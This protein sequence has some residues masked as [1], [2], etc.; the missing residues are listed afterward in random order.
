MNDFNFPLSEKKEELIKRALEE[1]QLPHYTLYQHI[2]PDG[3]SYIG[4]TKKKP[5]LR[6]G[7]DGIGYKGQKVYPKIQ[8]YGWEN[9]EHIILTDNIPQGK[10]PKIE[11]KAIAYFD[12]FNNGY[13]DDAGK[14]NIDYTYAFYMNRED[15]KIE[16]KEDFLT[17]NIFYHNIILAL[18]TLSH[19]GFNTFLYL[20]LRGKITHVNYKPR[21]IDN[22]GF[23]S[24]EFIWGQDF[25]NFKLTKKKFALGVKN[26]IENYY[27]EIID[28]NEKIYFFSERPY[29]SPY[30]TPE[31]GLISLNYVLKSSNEKE[32]QNVLL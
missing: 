11:Q 15:M 22:Y 31:N 25:E 20:L 21:F 17:L 28:E 13:N 1:H 10:A 8:K 16:N 4:I 29:T 14:E 23:I 2:F 7:K 19:D 30:S 9:I 6:W 26:L 24:P 18:K 5:E 27:V 3:K 32:V 12:S